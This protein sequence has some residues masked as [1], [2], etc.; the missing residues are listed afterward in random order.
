[1]RSPRLGRAVAG[2]GVALE[3]GAADRGVVGGE[4][5]GGEL[6]L[7]GAA[8]G[9]VRL[10]VPCCSSDICLRTLWTRSR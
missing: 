1:M 2:G 4:A 3:A 8:E 10:D 6:A 5:R 9:E 7:V